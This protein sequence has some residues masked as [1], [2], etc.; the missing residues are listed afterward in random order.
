MFSP[1]A[2][3]EEGTGV[4]EKILFVDDEPAVLQGYQRLLRGEFDIETAVGGRGALIAYESTGPYAVVVSDMRMPGMSGLELLCE[5]KRIAPDTVRIMLTGYSQMEPAIAAVNEGNIFRFLT[6]PCDKETLGKALNAALVQHRLVRAERDLLEDT[7]KASTQVLSDVL[8]LVNPAAF[9]RAMRVRRYMSHIVSR[10]GLPR[11]WRY[12]VAA[13]MSQLGCVVLAPETIDAVFAGK[14]LPA[15]EQASYDSHPEVARGLLENIPRME[16]IAWMIAHQNRMASVDSD[17]ADREMADMRLG[18]EILQVAIGFDDLIRKGMSRVEAANRLMKQHRD[19]DQKVLF[20]LV[21]LD[22]E[23]GEAKTQ[24][25][26]VENLTP[27]LVLADDVY[28]NTGSLIVT[29][30]QEVTPVVILKFKSL[31]AT[32]SFTGTVTVVEP[33]GSAG[34]VAKA[35]AAR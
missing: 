1:R 29:R 15:E 32:G 10:M 27:G 33:T 31:Q 14:P 28:T 8:S 21:E 13:M 12:E 2:W 6:K 30:G 19:L 16:P 3:Y 22:P 34:E 20:A 18:A 4:Q 26:P 11:P 35:A 17:I 23:K 5:F 24:P 9:G 25:C 7:L